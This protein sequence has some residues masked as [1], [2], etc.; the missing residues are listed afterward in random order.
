MSSNYLPAVDDVL[1]TIRHLGQLNVALELTKAFR[2]MVVQE[3]V[4][5]LDVQQDEATFRVSNT[6]MCAALDGDVYLHSQLLPK[7]VRAHLKSLNIR[8]GKFVLSGFAYTEIEW[9]K[10]QHERIQPNYP[11][12]V[13]LHWKGETVRACME[14][15]SVNGMG[16]MVYKLFE[17]GLEIE[18]GSNVQLDFQFSADHIY[19]AIKGTIIYI[20]TIGRFLSTLGIRLFP[21]IKEARL[22]EK[23]IAQRKHEILVE[24]N[25]A[26]WELSKPRGVESLYF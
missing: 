22:L 18:P 1:S 17:K 19:T 16:I 2:G 6:E 5:I 15:I 8:K 25:Q 4:N 9:K 23:Y 21:K 10:R 24:L 13:N 14:N 20:N 26:Y 7:P 3:E 11:T 12:Y